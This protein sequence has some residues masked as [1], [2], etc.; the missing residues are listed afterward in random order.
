MAA[1]EHRSPDRESASPIPVI[2]VG[3]YLA[4]APGSRETVAGGIRQALDNVGF[5]VIVDHDVPRLVAVDPRDTSR[6]CAACGNVDADSRQSRDTFRCVA[7]GH[8]GQADVNAAHDIRR[9]RLAQLHGEERSL[10][11]T[12][13]TREMDR[14]A[15]AA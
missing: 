12:P 8:A 15:V 2:D 3:G 11:A 13:M 1:A 4:G 14:I 5:F 6:T 10:Q 7:C 9:R